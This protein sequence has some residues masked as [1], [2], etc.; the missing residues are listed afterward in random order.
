MAVP[1]L[2]TIV[3]NKNLTAT[4]DANTM[5]MNSN[6]T[7]MMMLAQAKPPALFA[8]QPNWIGA[9][10]DEGLIQFGLIQSIK[11]IGKG[12]GSSIAYQYKA[13]GPLG[14]PTLTIPVE[15]AKV[16]GGSYW[17]FAPVACVALDIEAK[18]AG[19]WGPECKIEKI[20]S[21]PKGKLVSVVTKNA[22]PDGHLY[23]PKSLGKDQFRFVLTNGAGKKVDVT[24]ILNVIPHVDQGMNQTD[25]DSTVAQ[26][27]SDGLDAWMASAQL[28][29]LLATASKA[30]TGFADLPGSAV[31][32]TIGEGPTAQ[33]TL[34]T[35][36]AGHGW[37]VDPTPLDTTDDYLPTSNPNVWQAKAGSAAEGKMDMLSVLLHEYGHAL[38]LEHSADARDFMATTLQ[39]GERRL[40]SSEE[41]ALMGQL[42]AQL[43]AQ[44]SATDASASNTPGTPSSPTAPLPGM[45]FASLGLLALGR[46]RGDRSG[47][48]TLFATS[49]QPAGGGLPTKHAAASAV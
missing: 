49:A 31:G 12:F 30:L 35:T 37:Y 22:W 36:A 11:N 28:S 20:I 44:S 8:P 45:P 23:T 33:I 13:E 21:L 16:V 17:E 24:F 25:S 26:E 9:N 41:L 15:V 6:A 4:E 39:P 10:I 7:E 48:Q 32:N 42:V 3:G 46:L 1:T 27:P 18:Q 40:P 2:K 38:G 19:A 14:M 34:D 43:K 29:G 5:D 47:V